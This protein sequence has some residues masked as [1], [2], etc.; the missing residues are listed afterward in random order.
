MKLLNK[1]VADDHSYENPDSVYTEI[2][3]NMK[4]LKQQI[5]NWYMVKT[6]KERSVQ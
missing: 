3:I 6:I 4:F 1:S 5:M 2:F